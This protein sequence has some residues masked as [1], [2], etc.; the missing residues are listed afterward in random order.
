L[1]VGARRH[2][3]LPLLLIA[4]SAGCWEEIKY[5]PGPASVQSPSNADEAAPVTSP[6]DAQ[7]STATPPAADPSPIA[8]E[9]SDQPAAEP[10][11]P[12][13]DAPPLELPD[14][15][16]ATPPA[17]D[18]QS[19]AESPDA[20]MEPSIATPP[21]SE[22][23]Q[24]EATAPQRLLLWQAAGKWS[25][26]AAMFAKQLPAERYEPILNEASAAAAELDLTLP[27][28]PSGVPESQTEQA[29]ITALTGAPAADFVAAA[30]E[31]YGPTAGSL[32][33][34]AIRSNLLL[35]TYSPR[36]DDLAA[37]AAEF[38]AAA[39]AS[40]LPRDVWAPVAE[41]VQNGGEYVAVRSAIFELHRAVEKLLATPSP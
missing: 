31:R 16:A 15:P 38:T 28:F 5:E 1:I 40:G 30:A 11:S 25:L 32:A 34:L 9:T 13:L 26:A 18:G 37:Q 7:E 21:A 29:V 12:P 8:S 22:P 24:A 6:T 39:E 35:L 19:G 41:L 27:P 36:R 4:A 20:G 2:W 3:T 17:P 33:E 10:E 23:S 14:Q